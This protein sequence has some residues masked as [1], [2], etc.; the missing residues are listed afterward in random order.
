ML[1]GRYLT[2]SFADNHQQPACGAYS[3]PQPAFE[4]MV[5]GG[6]LRSHNSGIIG[7]QRRPLWLIFVLI[8]W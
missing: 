8:I 3:L 6:T 4:V 2:I 1:P 5:P 7:L